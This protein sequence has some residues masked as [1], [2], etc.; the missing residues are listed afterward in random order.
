[1]SILN[2][3]SSFYTNESWPLPLHIANVFY[4]P[5][6]QFLIIP[7][8][9]RLYLPFTWA[10]SKTRTWSWSPKNCYM[11]IYKCSGK[12]YIRIT[13]YDARIHFDRPRNLHT[14]NRTQVNS[15]SRV[16][17]RLEFRSKR[18][19]IPSVFPL[20]ICSSDPLNV[21]FGR[22]STVLFGP[23]DRTFFCNTELFF[24]SNF[25]PMASFHILV[26]LYDPH[27][28]S[29]AFRKSSQ[30]NANRA[31]MGNQNCIFVF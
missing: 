18:I 26:L 8:I 14:Q 22:T 28:L 15:W 1:M 10:H 25:M 31:K 6:H 3:S 4:G 29:L 30:K 9:F 23:N 13:N 2:Y 7:I 12:N 27:A 17:F 24:A 5:Y 20:Y 21:W 19:S 16:L 11:S